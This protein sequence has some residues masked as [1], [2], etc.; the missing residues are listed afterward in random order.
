MCLPAESIFNYRTASV[1]LSLSCFFVLFQMLFWVWGLF[2]FFFFL[3]SFFFFFPPRW[4]CLFIYF[5]FC[6]HVVSPR[7]IR[8]AV[9][10]S[11]AYW[12]VCAQPP[13]LKSACILWKREKKKKKKSHIV[14]PLHSPTRHRL[15]LK[16]S[17]C[18]LYEQ[19]V[20]SA[21]RLYQFRFAIV[22][23]KAWGLHGLRASASPSCFSSPSAFINKEHCPRIAVFSSCL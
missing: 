22:W 18:E 19:A 1:R 2:F 8:L 23:K 12:N 4:P 11:A 20:C 9:K 3:S 5:L 13:L 15:P 10:I 14:F 17:S 21:V 16:L 6:I 7:K